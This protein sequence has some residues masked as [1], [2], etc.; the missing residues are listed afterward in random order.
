M[1]FIQLRWKVKCVDESIKCT[2]WKKRGKDA[3]EENELVSEETMATTINLRPFPYFI[4]FVSLSPPSHLHRSSIAPGLLGI[5]FAK[6][7]SDPVSR[8]SIH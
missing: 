7:H 2:K 8:L 3:R 5:Q 1:I 4:V 6:L